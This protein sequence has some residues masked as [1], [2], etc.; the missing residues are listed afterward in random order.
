MFNSAGSKS[1]TNEFRFLFNSKDIDE[2]FSTI[3]KAEFFSAYLFFRY[4][5]TA[6]TLLIS[7]QVISERFFFV[8]GLPFKYKTASIF[9]DNSI[10][11][12]F[13]LAISF[14][15]ITLT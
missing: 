15:E 11:S 14:L 6:A 13:S 3:S 4:V 7:E 8:T 2:L 5:I 12:I 1:S 10:S 9:V